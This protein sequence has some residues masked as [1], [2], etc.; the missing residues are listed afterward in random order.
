MESPAP[1][2]PAP[3][4]ALRKVRIESAEFE[5]GATKLESLP[6]PGVPE[7]AFAGRSNVGKSSLMNALVQR[8]G[9]VRTS[10][11]PGCT[12][13][14]NLFS[15]TI[16]DGTVYRMLDLPG[17]GYAKLSK[18]EKAKWGAMIEGYLTGRSTLRAVV[19]LVDIRRGFEEDDGQLA[20]FVE[21]CRTEAGTTPIESI[22]VATKLDKLPL[23]KR[24]P[25][26]AAFRRD[27]GL[28]PIG[29]SAVTGE[30][31]DEL[32]ARLL[33]ATAREPGPTTA[34][35]SSSSGAS[36]GTTARGPRTEF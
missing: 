31:R 28:K 19:L 26:L 22:L 9:L 17:Y 10:S 23:N 3:R 8:S 20:E 34:A 6:S 14:L 18:T 15:I 16:D 35:P 13:A 1:A 2:A 11:T 27:T 21:T 5:A 12:R 4:P 30:G 36:A 7:I 32:W 25:A 29:F 33:A 24:K